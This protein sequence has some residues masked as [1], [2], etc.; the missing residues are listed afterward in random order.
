MYAKQN[1]LQLRWRATT[2]MQTAKVP[3]VCPEWDRF[4]LTDASA[5][6]ASIV[7]FEPWALQPVYLS[8]LRWTSSAWPILN[9]SL[10]FSCGFA[11]RATLSRT[12]SPGRDF[13]QT[14][15]LNHMLCRPAPALQHVLIKISLS[16]VSFCSRNSLPQ[17][18]S[19]MSECNVH[20]FFPLCA[21]NVIKHFHFYIC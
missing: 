18:L 8:A 15:V 14:E 2:N 5:L 7:G 17:P 19:N 1:R 6:L 20:F 16:P 11:S 21:G 4:C 13:W 12:L 9:N 10:W 3:F